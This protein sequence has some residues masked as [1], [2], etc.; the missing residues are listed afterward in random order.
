MTR[1]SWIRSSSF[2]TLV[3]LLALSVA[4]VGSAGALTVTD[5]TGV[6]ESQVG[7]TVETTVAI[8]D[9]F[10]DQPDEW[11][12]RANT[13]LENVSWV[14]TVLQQGN[15]VNETTYGDQTFEQ[16]LDIDNNG[17]EVRIDVTGET[18]PVENYT[19]EPRQTFTL[20][21]LTSISGSSES[22]LNS[23][24]VYHYTNE[25][26]NARLAID[27]AAQAINETGGNEEAENDLDSAISSFENE[28]FG[29]AENLANDARDQAE[30]AQQSQ[31]QTQMIL[32]GA[33]ALLVVGLI[34]GG[35]YYWRS[36]QDEYGKLQ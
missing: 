30:S 3:V 27:D 29:N 4:A 18:P 33:A 23:S 12:L 25:S 8:E 1:M 6:N 13:Q 17:D 11:T 10:T 32:Y 34:G 19:Y 21:E 28:N 7:E 36:N 2:T 22:A 14:V 9:P 20:W 31:E 15:Q 26:R 24:E 35:V 16:E 5:Q